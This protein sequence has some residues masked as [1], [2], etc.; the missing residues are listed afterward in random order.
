MWPEMGRVKR[1]HPG[2]TSTAT[3]NQPHKAAGARAVAVQRTGVLLRSARLLS[4]GL[5]YYSRHS[6]DQKSGGSQEASTCAAIHASRSA[7]HEAA[8][9]LPFHCT[10][11][12]CEIVNIVAA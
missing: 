4:C 7:L 9:K 10:K 8:A 5:S 6:W 3:T 11:V 2:T 1:G 12:R